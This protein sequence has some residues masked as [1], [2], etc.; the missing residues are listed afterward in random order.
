[1]KEFFAAI[2][3]QNLERVGQLVTDD[4]ALHVLGEPQALSQAVTDSRDEHG[5]YHG[6]A[7]THSI[8]FDRICELLA[9]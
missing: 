5:S 8:S 9:I 4:L 7:A 3:S 6:I 1:M 2:D